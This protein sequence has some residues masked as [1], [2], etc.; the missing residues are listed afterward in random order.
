[1]WK[2]L[3]CYVCC[4]VWKQRSRVLFDGEDFFWMIAP[5]EFSYF[6]EMYKER[7]NKGM[8]IINPPTFNLSF[9]IC[10]FDGETQ[11]HGNKCGARATLKVVDSRV[12]KL[13][14]GYGRGTNTRGELMALWCLLYFVNWNLLSHIQIVGDSKVVID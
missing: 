14:M 7:V 4:E 8:W 13:K 12:Y 10:Y 6:G 2:V 1:M 5:K 3:P 9:P 11:E